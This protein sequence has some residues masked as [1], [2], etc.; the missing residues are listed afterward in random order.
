[1]KWTKYEYGFDM[2]ETK[3]SSMSGTLDDWPTQLTY[4]YSYF[5]D[6]LLVFVSVS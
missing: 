1:M 5:H 2:A 6:F 3:Y 4:S